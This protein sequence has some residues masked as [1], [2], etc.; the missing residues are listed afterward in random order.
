MRA[1]AETMKDDETISIM[2]RLADDYENLAQKAE[3]RSKG[4]KGVPPGGV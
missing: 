1:L 2:H 4:S 3:L